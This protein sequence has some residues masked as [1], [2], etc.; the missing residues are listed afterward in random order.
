[1][2]NTYLLIIEAII[3]FVIMIILYKKYKLDGLYGYI[4]IT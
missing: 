1:M 4:I 2:T 3:C